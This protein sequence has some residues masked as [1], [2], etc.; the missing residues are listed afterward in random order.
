MRA[1]ASSM[2]T[3][4]HPLLTNR[5]I[6]RTLLIVISADKG[7]AGSYGSSLIKVIQKRLESD[8]LDPSNT[9][10]ITVG[11]KA[12][13]YFSKRGYT[14]KANYDHWSDQLKFDQ[15]EPMSELVQ[16]L[17]LSKQ[18]DR[19]IIIY[20]NFISTLVQEV[21]THQLLPLVAGE[22]AEVIKGIV[23]RVG[24]WKNLGNTASEQSRSAHT[25]YVFEPNAEEITNELLRELFKIQI[26]HSVL[27]ANASEHSARMVAM[28]NASDNA[29]E[30]SRA[31]KL[32]FNKV[33]QAAI[34]RE[35]SEIVG[36]MESMKVND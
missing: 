30:I 24:K 15:V 4:T 26:Y 9:D 16:E 8:R 22:V 20:T 11:R 12:N 7:L 6:K 31:L 33:R 27:E 17:F 19:V 10:I 14:I 18:V 5:A 13:E 35:V 28:K 2:E 32:Q 34:T 25:N 3:A 23:P 21:F 29:K 36:G 1:V